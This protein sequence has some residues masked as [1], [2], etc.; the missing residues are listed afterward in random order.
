VFLKI[1]PDQRLAPGISLASRTLANLSGDSVF[2]RKLHRSG[3]TATAAF[4]L[5]TIMKS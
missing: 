3:Q 5:R 2:E 4:R 1:A